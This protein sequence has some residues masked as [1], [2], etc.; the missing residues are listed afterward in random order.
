MKIYKIVLAST[1][2]TQIGLNGATLDNLSKAQAEKIARELRQVWARP[3][4]GDALEVVAEDDVHDQPYNDA[5]YRFR[6]EFPDGEPVTEWISSEADVRSVIAR[7][8][9]RGVR[10]V[11]EYRDG[12]RESIARI[13]V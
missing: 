7:R 12:A 2:E 11:R 4:A 13:V 6:V 10:L 9:L 8:G 3:L 1:G 5:G